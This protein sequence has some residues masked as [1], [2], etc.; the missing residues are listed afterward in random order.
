[1]LYVTK[2]PTQLISNFLVLPMN[3]L[4]DHSK[5]VTVFKEGLPTKNEN[6]NDDYNWK[7]R[8]TLYKWDK[9]RKN[10]FINALKGRTEEIEDISQ[11]ID[12]GLVHTAGEHIQQ[13]LIKNC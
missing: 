4:S 6:V 8:G 9:N 12:A 1:M 3:E 13:L 10:I 2:N 11:R 5:I 7:K